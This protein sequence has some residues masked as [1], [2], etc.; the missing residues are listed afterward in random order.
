[1]NLRAAKLRDYPTKDDQQIPGMG[2]RKV[3]EIDQLLDTNSLQATQV[4]ES[5]CLRW[6]NSDGAAVPVDPRVEYDCRVNTFVVP[7]NVCRIPNI[8]REGIESPTTA[9]LLELP[10]EDD[11]HSFVHA[12]EVLM[13]G[14]IGP[15]SATGATSVYRKTFAKTHPCQLS[16]IY[17][18]EVKQDSEAEEPA[19]ET[20]DKSIMILTGGGTR[21]CTTATRVLRSN[22]EYEYVALLWN[23]KATY[24]DYSQD[25]QG[26]YLRRIYDSLQYV[27]D[28]KSP[29]P[30]VLLDAPDGATLFSPVFHEERAELNRLHDFLR[31]SVRR[32]VDF[33]TC[34][35]DFL[36]GPDVIVA[37]SGFGTN[38][39]R[40]LTTSPAQA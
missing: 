31:D 8:T 28:D 3:R 33:E 13:L 21:P 26:S 39:R 29:I 4:N 5:F 24:Q 1:M 19:V 32:N 7:R 11:D 36:D 6:K 27:F 14:A 38:Q 40:Q 17:A 23:W 12:G 35:F 25:E 37:E 15:V 20:K 34:S 16:R 9:Q 2:G 18:E 30:I 10:A 22:G